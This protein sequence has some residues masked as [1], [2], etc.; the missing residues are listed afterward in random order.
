ME[1]PLTI[2]QR[3]LLSLSPEVWLQF[4][5]STITRRILNKDVQT[6]QALWPEEME[7]A[8]EIKQLLSTI[9]AF[10]LP[11]VSY[12]PNGSITISNPIETYYQ[13]L[14]PGFDLLE[15]ALTVSLEPSAI[16]S[17]LACV[18]IKQRVECILDLGCQVIT[19]SATLRYEVG[20]AYNPTIRLN[21]QSANGNYNLSIGL[22]R[23]VPF[24]IEN[25]TFYLQVHIVGSVAF[26]V[27][28]GWPVIVHMWTDWRYWQHS[29]K[30]AR[31]WEGMVD[32]NEVQ[33]KEYGVQG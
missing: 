30:S 5:D 11:T 19:M 20:I 32:S 13:L 2:T 9:S 28:L 31:T 33:S 12:A 25:I 1:T 18:N 21:M 4:R 8:N 17:I 15:E 27:L 7:T 6:T 14:P 24:L 26:N 10:A 3:E 23:N 16:R 29:Q 22:A